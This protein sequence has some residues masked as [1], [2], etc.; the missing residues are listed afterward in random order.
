MSAALG[1]F[2]LQQVDRQM[3]RSDARLSQIRHTLEND[4]E[5][6]AAL[7]LVERAANATAE[8]EIALRE[9]EALVDAQQAKIAQAEASLYGGQV[10]NPKELQ[11]LQQDVVSLKRHASTLEERQLEA[12]QQLETAQTDLKNARGVLDALR[13]RRGAEHGQLLEE[14]EQLVRDRVRLLTERSAVVGDLARPALDMYEDLRHQRR[15]V[16]VAEISDDSCSA[17]GT[18]L[19]PALQQS[20]RSAAQMAQ[21]P[22]CRRILYGG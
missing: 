19:S 15:G 20:A 13:S 9:A 5:L 1:L 6:L 8:A 11:D 21:C 10:H 7:E 17:C 18:A 14:Q 4:A 16:A 12:M 22:T 3:D 2:R